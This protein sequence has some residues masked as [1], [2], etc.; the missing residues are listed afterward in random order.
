MLFIF[1]ISLGQ[2][3]CHSGGADILT[4]LER[5]GVLFLQSELT[6]TSDTF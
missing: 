4:E 6:F 1:S 2:K 5:F 3:K